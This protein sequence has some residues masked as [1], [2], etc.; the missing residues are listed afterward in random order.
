MDQ[1]SDLDVDQN[2]V[3]NDDLDLDQNSD[4]IVDPNSDKNNDENSDQNNDENSDQDI[5]QNSDDSELLNDSKNMSNE[6][7]HILVEESIEEIRNRTNMYNH[8]ISINNVVDEL[9]EIILAGE[10]F[11]AI[12]EF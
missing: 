9:T 11:G 1:N 7:S 12:D 8:N 3:L 2:S 5:G 10:T 6:V 4:Q